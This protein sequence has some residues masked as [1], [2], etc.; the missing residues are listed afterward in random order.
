MKGIKMLFQS[1]LIS[2]A[3]VCALAPMPAASGSRVATA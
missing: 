3:L 2:I 1:L